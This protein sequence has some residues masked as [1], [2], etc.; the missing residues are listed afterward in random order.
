MPIWP[1]ATAVEEQSATTN[2]MTRNV[3]DAEKGSGE[4]TQNIAGVAEAARGTSSSAQEWQKAASQLAEMAAQLNNLVG[5][6]KIDVK[7]ADMTAT[8]DAISRELIP[9]I[10]A[11]CHLPERAE[12]YPSGV[13]AKIPCAR[14]LPPR[15]RL[16]SP[17]QVVAIGVSTGGPDALARLL[18]SFP[19]N[20]PL[21][22]LIAQHM[23]PIF[24]SLLAAHFT[25]SRRCRCGN[26]S[27]GNRSCPVVWSSLRE[28]FTWWSAGR[29]ESFC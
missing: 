24:T 16:F 11:L 23:P 1:I 10:R 9:K 12:E 15:P 21:P 18:P 29:M 20:F 19:A 3:T 27:P 28:T 22:V 14:H 7:A 5:Q 13:L 25:A 8:I 17:P 26:A 2:E 4:I 6:F